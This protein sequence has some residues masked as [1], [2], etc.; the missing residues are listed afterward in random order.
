MSA[1]RTLYL[2]AYDIACPRRWRNVHRLLMA[3]KVA[4]Q[5]SA[6]ECWVTPAELRLLMR[7]LESLIEPA[8]DRIHLFQLDERMKVRCYG[9]AKTFERTFFLI[10]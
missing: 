4:G 2:I 1:G 8:E 10:A 6:F 9:V 3:Y 5:K 7:E